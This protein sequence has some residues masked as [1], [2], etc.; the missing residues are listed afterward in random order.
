[1][2]FHTDVWV[3]P[4][5]GDLLTLND[6]R[7]DLIAYLDESRLSHDVFTNL[8]SAC[9]EGRGYIALD[10]WSVLALFGVVARLKPD[11]DFAV[12][13]AGEEMRDIWVRE[14]IGGQVGFQVGPFNE[15]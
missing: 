9:T 10:S 8:V 5:G 11:I 14:F 4:L 13:G 6:L 12:K 2:S 7:S 3:Q 15:G 1:M